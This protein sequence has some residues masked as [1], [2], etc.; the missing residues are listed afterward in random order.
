MAYTVS[1]TDGSR[2]ITVADGTFDTTTY[3]VTLIGKNIT[4]YG[5]V[6]VKNSIRQ[7]ENFASATAP[8][9]ASPLVGQVWY[10]KTGKVLRVYKSASEGWVRVSTVVSEA[11]P[12]DGLSDGATYF[13]SSDNKL[14]VYSGGAWTDSSYP[15]TVT[16]E[17]QLVSA[18]GTPSSYGT[19]GRTVFLKDSAGV[20]RA[21]HAITYVNDSET[22][23]EHPNGETIMAIFSDHTEFLVSDVISQTDDNT[24]NFNWY[25]QLVSSDGFKGSDGTSGKI[26]KGLNLRNEYANTS[27]ALADRAIEADSVTG[28]LKIGSSY[29]PISTIVRSSADIVPDQGDNYDLGSSTNRWQDL[30]INGIAYFGQNAATSTIRPASGA[31]LFVGTT[32]NKVHEVH[33]TTANITTINAAD[34]NCT[35]DLIVTG[36]I[37]AN[38]ITADINFDDFTSTDATISNVITATNGISSLG[39]LTTA[40]YANIGATLTV[41]GQTTLNGSTRIGDSASDGVEFVADIISG[42]RPNADGQ[43]DIG[44]DAFRWRQLFVDTAIVTAGANVGGAFRVENADQADS[45]TDYTTSFRTDGGAVIRKNAWIGELLNVGTTITGGGKITGGGDLQIAGAITGAT[46]ITASGE[47]EGGS[48]DIN[49]VADISGIITAGSDVNATGAIT[50]ASLNVSTGT[51][52][53]GDGNFSGSVDLGNATSDTITMNGRVDSDI[54][55]NVNNSRDLGST[56]LKWNDVYA[57]TFQ[58]TATSAQYADLAEIYSSDQDYEAGTVVKLGGSAEVTAT[59]SFNDSE[60]FGVVST[61]PAYL[62][63][64]EAEGVPV[65]LTGRVPVK[66]EGR[67]KKGERLVSGSKTGFAKALG[68]NDYDMRSIIGRALVDKDTFDDG[69]IEVVVGVK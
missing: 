20:A 46:D 69:V 9:V 10:D 68:N 37:V 51:I 5:D 3:S 67:V 58:G 14:K 16:D 53:G 4:N 26:K 13:D 61:N 47:I 2:E 39:Y 56:S 40:G 34:I 30:H 48:L 44:A 36:N 17:Y 27:I 31:Q 18:L 21:V 65:A 50:G 62:M 35:E 23:A 15:G 45:A 63:N 66:V 7:L 38:S 41:T 11:Q 12:S 43:F 52:T 55:P 32:G 33:A 49:G 24:A 19:R 57:T 6:F 22:D 59:T 8:S 42:M 28:N 1:N 29:Y 54:V 60:V 25:D 64:S